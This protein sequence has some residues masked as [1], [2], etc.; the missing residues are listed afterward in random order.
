MTT[1]TQAVQNTIINQLV[2]PIQSAMVALGERGEKLRLARSRAIVF[3][4]TTY[5][6]DFTTFEGTVIGR[7]GIIH[8]PSI[9]I[10]EDG[11]RTF[12]CTCRDHQHLVEGTRR[13]GK[14]TGDNYA[15]SPCKH[16]LALGRKVWIFMN[17]LRTV[18]VSVDSPKKS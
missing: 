3:E 18:Q 7:D 12:H 17:R 13:Q 6:K 16:N 14:E 10:N 2:E 8:R 15:D 9:T 11:T 5:S 4:S 1:L